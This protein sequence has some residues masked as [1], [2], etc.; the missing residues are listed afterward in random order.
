MTSLDLTG[1]TVVFAGPSLPPAMRPDDPSLIW[2]GPA[3]AGDGV[4]MAACPPAAVV[5]LDGAFDELPSIRHK[6]LLTLVGLGVRVIGAAGMGALRAAELQPFGVE[7]WGRIFRAY[8]SG[9][10]V[11]DDE[12]A[13]AHA[14]AELGW[15]S[16][17]EP[18]VNVRATLLRALRRRV[19]GPAEAR[20]VL[21][22]ASGLFYRERTWSSVVAAAR[23]H[24]LMAGL[25]AAA[26]ESW[27]V[28]H[29]V[30]LKLADALEALDAALEQ[31]A[32]VQARPMPPATSFTRALSARFAL[33]QRQ[34]A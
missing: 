34:D 21:G 17:S 20:V 29:R 10:L 5:M 7:G 30:D 2:R 15:R 18:L 16:L 32:M 8:A 19:L 12:V 26:L 25:D 14:P 3:R 27:L 9:R 24:P 33:G 23:T 13:V 4:A 6:E 31:P 1:R 11:G 22:S 28:A